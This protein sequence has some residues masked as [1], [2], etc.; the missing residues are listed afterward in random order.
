VFPKMAMLFHVS[1]N[2]R[3]LGILVQAVAAELRAR[4]AYLNMG[5]RE[6]A[7][8]ARLAHPTVSKSLSGKRVIDVEELGR[9][10]HALGVSPASIVQN[11][12]DL[13]R[14]KGWSAVTYIP[15]IA[16]ATAEDRARLGIEDGPVIELGF[17]PMSDARGRHGGIA[18]LGIPGDYEA[19][20][21]PREP[22]EPEEPNP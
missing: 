14:D 12:L 9:L 7:E 17:G 15:A 22:I 5:V 21:Y 16:T 4:R 1:T 19:V 2:S 3:E 8:K 18:H 11:A 6:L 13:I 10:A 20:A